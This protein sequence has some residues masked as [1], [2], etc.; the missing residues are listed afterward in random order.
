MNK[1]DAKYSSFI[2]TSDGKVALRIVLSPDSYAALEKYF[3][4]KSGDTMTG[5]LE[6]SPSGTTSLTIKKDTNFYLDGG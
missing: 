2:E 1:T 3:V 5:A 4:K 6:I